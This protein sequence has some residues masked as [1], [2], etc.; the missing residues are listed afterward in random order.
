MS[1]YIGNLDQKVNEEDLYKHFG[2]KRTNLFSGNSYIECVMV[3]QT[4][5]SNGY[6]FFT[7]PLHISEELMKLNGSEFAGKNLLIEKAKKKHKI[8]PE[9]C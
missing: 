5:K 4:G 1:L 6:G 3:D 8:R 7:V 2:G 9:T